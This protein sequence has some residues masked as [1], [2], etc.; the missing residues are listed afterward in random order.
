MAASSSTPAPAPWPDPNKK[1]AKKQRTLLYE[2]FVLGELHAGPFHGYLLR[3]ILN[4]I[5]GPYKQISWGTLY[6]LIHRLEE[7]GFVTVEK[8]L[9]AEQVGQE[10]KG[11][12][13]NLYYIT[14]AGRAYF[15]EIINEPIPYE[16]YEPALFTMK[17]NYFDFVTWQEQQTIL[18]HH[19][20]YLAN[21][22]DYIQRQRQQVANNPH[23]PAAERRRI[24]WVIGFRQS[25]INA[26]AQWVDG[27]LAEYAVK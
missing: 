13:R 15:Q 5:L 26:E 1:P 2:L 25:G 9:V 17:L 21:Q 20:T 7:A 3:E 14:A 22:T 11:K 23:I 4:N 6:P 8:E 16:S 10:G 24:D 19:Q 27:A 12:Q 18:Q